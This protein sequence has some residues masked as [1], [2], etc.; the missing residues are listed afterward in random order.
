MLTLQELTIEC[1]VPLFI[2]H[3]QLHYDNMIRHVKIVSSYLLWFICEQF[4]FGNIISCSKQRIRRTKRALHYILIFLVH[5]ADV[6]SFQVY[7]FSFYQKYHVSANLDA[8]GE[9]SFQY[10]ILDATLLLNTTLW[11]QHLTHNRQSFKG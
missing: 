6:K 1:Q 5:V 10:N 11:Y 8:L 9:N 4:S 3:V 7:G 2:S